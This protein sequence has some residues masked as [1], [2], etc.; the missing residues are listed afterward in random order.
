MTKICK[1]C[2]WCKNIY[3]TYTYAECN[4][5]KSIISIDLVNGE[6]EYHY[7]SVNREDNRS[8]GKSGKWFEQKIKKKKWFERKRKKK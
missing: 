7:C 8:C 3:P 5:P 1:D 6:V 2:K 4:N